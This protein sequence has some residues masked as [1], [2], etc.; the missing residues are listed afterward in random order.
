M[1]FL[2]RLWNYAAIPL[3]VLAAWLIFQTLFSVGAAIAASLIHLAPS[4]FLGPTLALSSACTVAVL[5]A[6]PLFGLR[7]AFCEGAGCSWTA[8]A[9]GVAG[10]LLGA[11]GC[12]LLN[13]ACHLELPDN[14]E[15]LFAT[16]GGS[17]WGVAALTVLGPLCEELVF[18]GG[19]MRP[20]L[21]QGVRPWVAIGVSALLFGL[22]HGNLAQGFFAMLLGILFGILYYRTGNLLLS[23]LCHIVNNSASVALMLAYGDQAA[24]MRLSDLVGGPAAAGAVMV[25]CL[26]L[27]LLLVTLFW[28]KTGGSSRSARLG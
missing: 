12:D 18:R 23:S 4:A 25:A 17:A 21:R 1:T 22:M 6:V 24:D 11:F 27:C 5:M 2:K 16:V 19:V 9:L 20:L 8:G 15:A 10:V 13:E 3:L 14:Y 28:R 7:H 26:L